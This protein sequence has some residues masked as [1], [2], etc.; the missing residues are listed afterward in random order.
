MRLL[1]TLLL[2]LTAMTATASSTHTAYAGSPERK[3]ILDIVR[4]PLEQ[5][6]HQP[7]R[8]VV[9][10][11]NVSG[12]W[13]FLHA[14]L[15]GTDG[16]PVDYTGTAFAEAA[17]HGAMSQVYAALLQSHAGHWTM[18]AEAVGPTDP[19][20]AGWAQQYGAPAALFGD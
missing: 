19:A 20:W 16:Q 6:L 1:A 14:H 3:A 2:S 13:A 7:V 15:Q 18:K 5:R 8:F 11:L 17:S 9:D 10:R 12:D 4:A